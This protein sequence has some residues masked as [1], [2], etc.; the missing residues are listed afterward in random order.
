MWDPRYCKE[1]AVKMRKGPLLSRL[2]YTRMLLNLILDLPK[3]FDISVIS[4]RMKYTMMIC[5][6]MEKICKNIEEIPEKKDRKKAIKTIDGID[7]E[8]G[9]ITPLIWR[10]FVWFTKSL[11]TLQT[12]LQCLRKKLKFDV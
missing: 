6:E 5:D 11:L 2:H 4:E 8:I 12:S 1:C 7:K 3:P 9:E 10:Q